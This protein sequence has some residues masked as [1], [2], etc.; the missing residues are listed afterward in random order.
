MCLFIETIC[1]KDGQLQLIDLHNSRCNRTR[2]YFFGPMHNLQLELF[3]SV[4]KN[5]QDTTVKC[6]VVYG[7]DVIN[8]EYESYQ[9]R[10]VKSLRL[11]TDNTID[12]AFK[13]AD[14]SKLSQLYQL[15]GQADDILIIKDGF[16]TDTYYA[17]IVLM[18]DGRWYS[19]QNPLLKGIRLESY[20]QENV[21][22]PA[23]I[24]PG[25]LP[26]YS[27]ARIIN[28]MIPI[29]NSPVIPINGILQ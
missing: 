4:P 10:P 12:Y 16:I 21:V 28:A 13:Y 11:V 25:D 17:N 27:E 2:N 18:K 15:R 26:F 5:L 3:I 1:Y 22:I 8:I 23:H 24:R 9:I 14:R 19:P 6:R 29:E 7:K 20:L